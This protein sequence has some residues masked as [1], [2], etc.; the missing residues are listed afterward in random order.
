MK[1]W[2]FLF[3]A[4]LM[5]AAVM[6]SSCGGDDD[7]PVDPGPSINLRGE[8][9]YTAK[10]DTIRVNT[11]IKV[12]V[13]GLKS[14]VSG[15]K[16]TR[17]KFSIISNNVP[18]TW[19][20]TTFSSD[21]FSWEENIP[22]TGVG[23]ARLLFELWDKGGMRN[24]QAFEIVVEDPGAAINKFEDIK[25]GSWNDSDGSFFASTEGGA[26]Y[27]VGQ[28]ATVP[29]N[30]AKI[31]FLYFHGQT[32]RNTIASP[33]DADANTINDLK[34][35]LW[36]NKNQTRFNPINLTV[37][38]FNAIGTTYKFPTFDINSQTTKMNNLKVND[39]FMFK[40]QKGKLGLIMVTYLST[41]TRG[42]KLT[43][44]VIVQK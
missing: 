19:I 32:N 2:N 22:F 15:E 23:K 37:E 28:T 39:I 14:S 3:M 24:E 5:S 40:T 34:L 42:D 25:F 9:G 33:D 11:D 6:V 18:T 20:D 10:D 13:T 36:T 4:L 41:P 30:Q 29:A 38:Q 21:S 43:A 31:D 44:T 7:D 27:T 1:K 26:P 8:T 35:N 12:G 16:L 17:F